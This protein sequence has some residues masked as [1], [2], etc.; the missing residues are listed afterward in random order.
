MVRRKQP[1]PK[2]ITADC[3]PT[4]YYNFMSTSSA[5]TN[6]NAAAFSSDA[7]GGLPHPRTHSRLDIYSVEARR[8]LGAEFERAAQPPVLVLGM[9]NEE[10]ARRI[11]DAMH[12]P[13]PPRRVEAVIDLTQEQE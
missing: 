4:R 3:P 9:S 12:R 7:D 1:N 11:A 2:R 5:N 13:Q 10:H 6:A 8:R